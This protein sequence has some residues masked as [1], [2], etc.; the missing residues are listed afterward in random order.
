MTLAVFL[1]RPGNQ[2]ARVG[3][4]GGRRDHAGV[5]GR[6]CR[7]FCERLRRVAA[8]NCM[9]FRKTGHMDSTRAVEATLNRSDLLATGSRPR[10][11]LSEAEQKGRRSE[12]EYE[13][14]RDFL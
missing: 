2:V 12:A 1:D 11:E 3:N 13:A 4:A 10:R 9:S 6:A 8:A 5:A 14:H 7:S